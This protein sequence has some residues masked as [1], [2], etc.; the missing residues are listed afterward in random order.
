MIRSA[1]FLLL[2]ALVGG[3][4]GCFIE[5]PGTQDPNYPTTPRPD[6]GRPGAPTTATATVVA[7]DSTLDPGAL[8]AAVSA[9]GGELG[10]CFVGSGQVDLVVTLDTNGRP[11]AVRGLGDPPCLLPIVQAATFP[12]PS[13]PTE[14]QVNLWVTASANVPTQPTPVGAPPEGGVIPVS[15]GPDPSPSPSPNPAPAPAP[16]NHRRDVFLV[17]IASVRVEPSRADGRPWDDGGGAASAPDLF[18][19]LYRNDVEVIR[20]DTIPDITSPSFSDARA[21]SLRLG[22]ADV[23]RFEI[24]ED[25][26]GAPEVVTRFEVPAPSQEHLAQG[27]W[28]IGPSPPMQLLRI[29]L[30]TPRTMIGTGIRW[31]VRRGA[32]EVLEIALDSPAAL[33][34]VVVGDRI[35]VVDGQRVRG[36]AAGA[37]EEL[38]RGAAGSRMRLAVEH[39]GQRR[40]VD[41]E[42][43]TV[44]Y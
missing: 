12:R 4:A 41:L 22:P 38:F 3:L 23:L 43:A 13:V 39:A 19:K 21:R 17:T 29:A 28:E 36:V 10:R 2:L 31:E 1:R 11:T 15:T 32:L 6:A 14:F 35:H 25:D 30:A 9:V 40:Q 42:R 7:G 24:W 44:F 37:L 20:T 5:Q 27:T 18:V 16:A 34:G 8:A 26:P 33:A